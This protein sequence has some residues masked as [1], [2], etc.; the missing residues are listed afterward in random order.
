MLIDIQ[1]RDTAKRNTFANLAREKSSMRLRRGRMAK[2]FVC[3]KKLLPK[4]VWCDQRAWLWDLVG[5]ARLRTP[6][7]SSALSS[8]V[9]ASNPLLQRNIDAV[10]HR[11]SRWLPLEIAAHSKTTNTPHIFE[12]LFRGK[13]TTSR[14]QK[15]RVAGMFRFC[16]ANVLY[17]LIGHIQIMLREQLTCLTS[18]TIATVPVAP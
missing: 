4:Q 18:P 15:R 17:T 10:R 13:N 1:R 5:N 14:I 6:P 9:T 7:A 11:F 12:P 16:E 2:K 3:A 8:A